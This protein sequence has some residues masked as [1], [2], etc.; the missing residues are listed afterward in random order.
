MQVYVFNGKA[1]IYGFTADAT[2][3]N[4]PASHGPWTPRNAVEMNRGETPRI[5][6][7]TDEALNNIEKHGF[8]LQGARI[9]VTEGPANA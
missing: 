9:D 6:V 5:A 3:A 8:H 1:T 7:D 2:G 4:L